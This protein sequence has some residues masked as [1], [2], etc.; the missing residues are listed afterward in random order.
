MDELITELIKTGDNE[1]LDLLLLENPAIADSRIENGVSLLQYAAYCRNPTA[2]EILKKYK[3]EIDIYEATCIGDIEEVER[4]LFVNMKLLHS[5]SSDGFTLLG[6]A[7]YFGHFSIVRFLLEKGANPSTPANNQLKVSP[8]HSACAIS[9]YEIAELLIK[10]GAN[11][12]AKQMQGA[13]ALHSAAHN[14]KTS[15][16]KLLIDN[17]ADVNSK[18]ENGKTP[19]AMA[20]ERKFIET[21]NLIKIHG[22]IE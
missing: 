10:Y 14:G 5:F 2:V 22:G 7:S 3:S 19:L 21:A 16:T 12:N 4:A 13:T 1:K 8:L 6:L 15:L 9:N 20:T 11:L 18:M 17:G